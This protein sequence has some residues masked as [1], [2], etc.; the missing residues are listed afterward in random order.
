MMEGDRPACSATLSPNSMCQICKARIKLLKYLLKNK[1]SRAFLGQN[2]AKAFN[3]HW[4]LRENGV[5]RAGRSKT[6][7]CVNSTTA[8]NLGILPWAPSRGQTLARPRWPPRTQSRAPSS[9]AWPGAAQRAPRPDFWQDS[10]SPP[11]LGSVSTQRG[12]S[13]L[14]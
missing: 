6:K 9:P 14:S 5:N 4:Q 1:Q 11:L 3:R 2:R 13:W 7:P 10:P 12:V 8:S